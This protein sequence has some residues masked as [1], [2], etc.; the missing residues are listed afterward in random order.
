MA[1]ASKNNKI[2]VA[3]TP[4]GIFR[5]P[6][7]YFMPGSQVNVFIRQKTF[8]AEM[9]PLFKNIKDIFNKSSEDIDLNSGI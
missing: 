2:D 7:A 6:L 3:V 5:V 4:H 1:Q 8:D 9:L